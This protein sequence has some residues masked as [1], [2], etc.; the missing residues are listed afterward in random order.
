MEREQFNLPNQSPK[1]ISQS[2][3]PSLRLS[4]R[5]PLVISYWLFCLDSLN[6][7]AQLPS[8]LNARLLNTTLTL[9]AA[10]AAL[11]HTGL[12]RQW[13]PIG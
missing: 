3:L 4:I 2:N 1:S 13:L 9:L 11:A 8:H 6:T 12:N 7:V 5:L 10:I